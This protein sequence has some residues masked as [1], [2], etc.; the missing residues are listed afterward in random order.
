MLVRLDF[1]PLAADKSFGAGK[2][3][4]GAFEKVL[5]DS[6]LNYEQA[7]LWRVQPELS[8]QTSAP[9]SSQGEPKYKLLVDA[10]GIYEVSYSEL[11][12][13]GLPLAAIDPQTFR[14]TNRG[15]EVAIF[16]PGEGDGLFDPGDSLLFYGLSAGTRFTDTN[17]Y[18]LSW[19]DGSGLRMTS[20]DGSPGG[21]ASIPTYYWETRRVEQNNG[22]WNS[23]PSGPERERWYWN[24]VV[25]TGSPVSK[26]YPFEIHDPFITTTISA[27]VRGYLY[28]YYASPQHHTRVYLNGYLLDDAYWPSAA[29]HSFEAEI[30]MSLIQDGPNTI[31]LNLPMGGGI[32]LD[33]VLVNRFELDFAR[34]FTALSDELDFRSQDQGPTEFQVAGFSSQEVELYDLTSPISPTRLTGGLVEPFESG[35]RLRFE[36]PMAAPRRFLALST[37]NRRQVSAILPYTSS[38]L[39]AADNAAD[40]IVITHPDFYS[41]VQPLADFRAAQGLRVRVIDVN[42][43]YDEFGDGLFDPEAIRSFLAHAFKYWNKP[44]PSL[45]LLVGD[46]NYD[47]KNWTGIGEPNYIPPYLA[48]VDP[49]MVETAADNRYVSVSGPD[50]LPDMALGRLPVRS[51][52]E[53]ADLVSKI[54]AYEGSDTGSGWKGRALFVADNSDDDG[55]YPYLSEHLIQDALPAGYDP[56]RMHYKL[57]HFTPAS[58]RHAITSTLEQGALLVNYIGHGTVELVG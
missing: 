39:H 28:G 5:Q 2:M 45:V 54:I 37:L 26:T 15:Q 51:P 42:T 55:N 58:A 33:Y 46:G 13:A 6:L 10:D 38:N 52:Q 41:S 53:T 40:Y 56:V 36:Q 12:A 48:D 20:I 49:Y 22:Y 21:Y 17:V 18:W 34:K 35:Y 1:N 14:L 44:A 47:F 43:I 19:G 9:A 27:T 57:T 11:A 29:E 50:F 32:S 3:D 31:T 4:E 25:S 8:L 30:P 16:I 23:Q 24:M 7:R